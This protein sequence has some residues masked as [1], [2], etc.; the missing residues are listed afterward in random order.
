VQRYDGDRMV[1][2]SD[3]EGYRTMSAQLVQERGLIEPASASP[4]RGS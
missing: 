4:Q 2:L 1:V 3:S